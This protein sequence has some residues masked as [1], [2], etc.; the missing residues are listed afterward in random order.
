MD[1]KFSPYFCIFRERY[2]S[3]HAFFKMRETW[4]QQHGKRNQVGVLL[5]DLPKAFD[6]INRSSFLAKLEAYGFSAN[7]IMKI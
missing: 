2:D 5:M 7:N 4:K 6:T 3:Q 1:P